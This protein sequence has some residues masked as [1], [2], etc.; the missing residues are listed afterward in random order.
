M[1]TVKC[2]HEDLLYTILSK[3]SSSIDMWHFLQALDYELPR[4]IHLR[5]FWSHIR[6]SSLH[7]K[8]ILL[9]FVKEIAKYCIDLRIDN[10]NWM[11]VVDIRRLLTN[12]RSLI[13]FHTGNVALSKSTL[14]NDI[15]IFFPFLKYI[16]LLISLDSS[17]IS[18]LSTDQCSITDDTF[19]EIC[20]SLNE[21]NQ[22]EHISL[23]L[24]DK[25]SAYLSDV[26]AK[27]Y[28]HLVCEYI[29]NM[30]NHYKL[31]SIEENGYEI[32]NRFFSLDTTNRQ[33]LGLINLS[34]IST[35]NHL[36]VSFRPMLNINLTLNIKDSMINK[37]QL[38]T[39]VLPCIPSTLNSIDILDLNQLKILDIG[40]VNVNDK[41][42]LT[43]LDEILICHRQNCLRNLTLSLNEWQSAKL[44]IIW[45]KE[46]NSKQITTSTKQ[47]NSVFEN[48][49][50]QIMTEEEDEEEEEMKKPIVLNSSSD[51]EQTL[52][53]I[54]DEFSLEFIDDS[55][56]C[57]F[58]IPLKY[59]WLNK[60][61]NLN[62]TGIHCHSID[63]K[64]IFNSL[65]LLRSLS[66]SPCLLLYINQ[67]EC[68][69]QIKSSSIPYEIHS[70]NKNLL[71]LN[72]ISHI[73][74]MKQTCS[75]FLDQYKFHC[76]RHSSIHQYLNN[77]NELLFQYRNLIHY[78]IQ[79]I[80][81]TLDLHHLSIRIPNYEFYIDDFNIEKINYLQTLIFDIK[82]PM[83]FHAKLT[84]L[85]SK[86][87]FHYLRRFILISNNNFQLTPLLI[88]KFCQLEII[89]IISINSHLNRSTINYL[90]QVLKPNNYPN[91]NLFRFW[92]GSVD[93]KHLLKHLHKTIRLAFEN[94]KP[95]FQFDISIINQL[96]EINEISKCI[97][98]DNTHEIHQYF[99]SLLSIHSNQVSIIYPN[100]L[101]YKPL[102]SEQ[103]FDK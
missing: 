30:T 98:Y 101:N 2:L 8:N 40:Y 67:F 17:Q 13:C 99:H 81:Q 20:T 26:S 66:L 78:S 6:L 77:N 51:V 19:T 50:D 10:L 7:N 64:Y 31:I 71:S 74:N 53:N 55:Q 5:A 21:I 28:F 76:I 97:L 23:V 83:T 87:I 9:S 25:K 44:V 38:Q 102:Y 94:I 73:S 58:H 12:F 42:E 85:Y 41:I 88:D 91:L 63:F 22:L 27:I 95:A 18:S 60:L 34:L 49:F 103:K 36:I 80:I 11:I 61:T 46:N 93:A 3:C 37:L 82:I 86:N 33:S 29:S 75:I 32:K 69:C 14:I 92:I 48:C 4:M 57:F 52:P 45:K 54:I 62:L 72:L 100:F 1:T 84:N 56:S 24:Q 96:S 35:L 79:T 65:Y 90:Q 47:F 43:R 15:K 16:T 59:F 68:Y 70:L 39:L 89:E